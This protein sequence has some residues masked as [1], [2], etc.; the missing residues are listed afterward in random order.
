MA[1]NGFSWGQFFLRLVA[2]LALVFVSYNPSGLSYYQWAIV[3][4]PEYDVLQ[5]FAGVVLIIA[6]VIFLRATFHSLGVIGIVLAV[7]FFATLLW[8]LVDRG[9]IQ[10]DSGGVMI[11]L[12]LVAIAG[13]L[14]VGMSWSHIRRRLSGQLDVDDDE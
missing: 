6:W 3:P 7:A 9:L 10:F 12:V 1:N 13:V 2:A 11:Y 4:L 5:I 8:L 14:A